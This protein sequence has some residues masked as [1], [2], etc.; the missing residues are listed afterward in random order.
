MTPERHR[1]SPGYIGL[2]WCHDDC[3]AH[4]GK[5]V[6]QQRQRICWLAVVSLQML[7]LACG[8]PR[9]SRHSATPLTA[10]NGATTVPTVTAS[11]GLAAVARHLGE[12]GYRQTAF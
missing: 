10:S 3:V 2:R 12:L 5:R 9:A 8:G 1:G 6:S 7:L 11:S 4:R